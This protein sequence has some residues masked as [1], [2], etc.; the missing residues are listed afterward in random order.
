MKYASKLFRV[1]HRL[2]SNKE[3]EGTGVGLA[4]VKRIIKKHGGKVWAV[5]EEGV[6]ATFYFSLPREERISHDKTRNYENTKAD[7]L[8]ETKYAHHGE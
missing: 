6:G 1:F 3:F 8:V 2:H 4:I 5:G 7:K